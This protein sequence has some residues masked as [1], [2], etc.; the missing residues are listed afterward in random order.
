MI[1]Q[2]RPTLVLDIGAN[3]GQFLVDL[4]LAKYQGKVLAV[5]PLPEATKL[6]YKKAHR[7]QAITVIPSALTVDESDTIQMY[8]GSNLGMSSSILRPNASYS[9]LDPTTSF[10]VL[11]GFS[12]ISVSELILRFP[13]IRT[14]TI[15][16][17][18]DVQGYEC[19]I[20]QEFLR[21]GVTI[22]ALI[23]ETHL[24]DLYEGSGNLFD[25]ME[26]LHHLNHRVLD[27]Q[28]QGYSKEHRGWNY[29][30]IYSVVS[31]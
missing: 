25:Y 16:M 2:T 30:D 15:L 1:E 8:V 7:N 3:I 21:E 14:S 26:F 13:E 29:T 5:E 6:L 4:E 31:K 12:S 24:V 18:I 23:G 17:K 19:R 20:L 9:K 27:I 28:M 10:E 11:E 22:T